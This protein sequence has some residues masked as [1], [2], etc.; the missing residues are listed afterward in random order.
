MLDRLKFPLSLGSDNHSGIH[1]SAIESILACNRGSAHAY[2]MDEVSELTYSEFQRVFGKNVQAEYVF[3]GTAANVL[4]IQPFVKSYES[5]I[6]SELAHLHVDECGAPEKFLGTKLWTVPTRDGR[7]TPEQ[8]EPLLSR[9][10][11]Q[12]YSQPKMVSLTLPTEMGVV[13]QWEELKELRRYT[14]ENGLF[15]HLDGARLA[16]AAVS[17]KKDLGEITAGLGADSV[18][19]GGTKNGLMGA[20]CVLFFNQ[21]F[22]NI[23]KFYRKQAMQLSSKTRFLAAQMYAYLK[24]DLW[25]EIAIHVTTEARELANQLQKQHPDF[26]LSFPVHSNALFVR[27]PKPLIKPLREKLFFYIWDGHEDL[28]RWMISFDW[29]RE[30]SKALLQTISEVKKHVQ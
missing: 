10:G 21:D 16:N 18:S 14:K 4:A 23:F 29:T 19:F 8:I 12:H 2:G 11:D 26:K 20:E 22:K 9:R 13:Y 24:N 25:R 17:L 6:C 5:V 27:I 15:L 1:P 30:N 28:A 3:T 7:I